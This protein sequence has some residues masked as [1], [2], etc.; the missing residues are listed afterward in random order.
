MIMTVVN[1][2]N[3]T[4]L[5]ISHIVCGRQLPCLEFTGSRVRSAPSSLLIS[6][7][8]VQGGSQEAVADSGSDAMYGMDYPR[9]DSCGHGLIV[10]RPIF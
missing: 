10:A 2:F 9:A 1:M 8:R 3:T 4:S 5:H 7:G 6:L